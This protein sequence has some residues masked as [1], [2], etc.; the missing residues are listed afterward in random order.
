[1]PSIFGGTSANCATDER[2][3]ECGRGGTHNDQARFAYDFEMPIGTVVRAFRGGIVIA[4][5][6]PFPDFNHTPAEENQVFILHD[7]GTVARYYHLTQ[8]GGLV[9][10]G[11][12]VSTG[13]AIALSGAAGYIGFQAIPH[14]HFDVTVQECG[15]QFFG[16]SCTAMN[17]TRRFSARWTSINETG[18]EPTINA[19][20]DR[21]VLL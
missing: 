9:A 20:S 2:P 11:S 18:R 5:E 4:V 10:P 19:S 12:S 6:Q 14:L 21:P 17:G 7:D 13:Q 1:M 15:E 3:R 16:S 8:G